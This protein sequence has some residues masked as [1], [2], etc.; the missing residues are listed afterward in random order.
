MANLVASVA[1]KF[2]IHVQG[3]G[4][5]NDS[6][7]FEMLHVFGSHAFGGL[8]GALVPK[9]LFAMV[10]QDMRGGMELYV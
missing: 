8:L 2:S 1:F 7:L 6:N 10:G 4:T 3:M 9:T 5:C